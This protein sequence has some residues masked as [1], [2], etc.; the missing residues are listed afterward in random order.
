MNRK[1]IDIKLLMNEIDSLK[2]E[3]NFKKEKIEYIKLL[4]FDEIKNVKIEEQK[5]EIN[6]EELKSDENNEESNFIEEPQLTSE[7]EI[8]KNDIIEEVDTID[9][10]TDVKKIYRQ[11]VIKTHPDK[12]SD[13]NLIHYYIESVESYEK[14]DYATI[15]FIAYKLGISLIG[16]SD[17]SLQVI[18]NY[19]KNIN[20]V[21]SG[22]NYNDF[23]VWYNTDN[24]N[25][26]KIILNN[27][28]K[29]I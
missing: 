2:T 15:F 18:H 5:E 19:K 28:I 25:L 16:I 14:K 7:Q 6:I 20:N 9:I 10:P 22:L 24:E 21:L 12:T 1:E 23:I 29:K 26:K 17:E 27:L 4:I 3:L 13:K 8:I 11:I